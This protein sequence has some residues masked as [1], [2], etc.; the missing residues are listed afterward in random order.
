MGKITKMI[1]G[2][3]Y[4]FEVTREYEIAQKLV[5]CSNNVVTFS[6]RR[7]GTLQVDIFAQFFEA[8]NKNNP[9]AKPYGCNKVNKLICSLYF[10]WSG[11]IVTYRAEIP[12]EEQLLVC[13]QIINLLADWDGVVIKAVR[14]KKFYTLYKI[15]AK[16][17]KWL[18]RDNDKNAILVSVDKKYFKQFVYQAPDRLRNQ[19]RR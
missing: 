11:N 4:E 18:L 1:N 9:Y 14:T 6:F 16:Y 19:K 2:H 15:N 3:S 5:E 8:Y 17:L 12:D 7:I 13:P 10:N